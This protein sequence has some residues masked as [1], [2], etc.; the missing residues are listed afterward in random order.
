MDNGVQQRVTDQI[1]KD[2]WY[3]WKNQ[4]EKRS[5]RSFL[6]QFWSYQDNYGGDHN[7]IT[8]KVTD[9][10]INRSTRP[11]PRNKQNNYIN[12]FIERSN[13]VQLC[14]ILKE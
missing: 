5:N 7:Y 3:V 14:E 4:R 6:R 1:M 11:N 8:F 13:A 12:G 10:T 2:I 9:H